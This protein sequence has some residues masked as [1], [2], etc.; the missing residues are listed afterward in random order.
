[1]DFHLKFIK[2]QIIQEK[3]KIDKIIRRNPLTFVLTGK[4]IGCTMKLQVLHTPYPTLA[5]EPQ[6][7][8]K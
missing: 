5:L 7:L 6:T 4:L 2:L 1:M 3:P 8:N